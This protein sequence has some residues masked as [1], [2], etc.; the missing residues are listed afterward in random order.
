[1]AARTE[2]SISVEADEIKRV[3]DK[4]TKQKVDQSA[5]EEEVEDVVKELA[6]LEER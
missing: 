1:L 3:N 2:N 5:L 4:I 6:E